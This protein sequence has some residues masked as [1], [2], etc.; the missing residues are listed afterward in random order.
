MT[1]KLGVALFGVGRAGLIHL[2]NLLHNERAIVYYL[3]E[4]DLAKARDVIQKYHMRDTNAV[5]A[6]DTSQVYHDDRYCSQLISQKMILSLGCSINTIT[7][8]LLVTVCFIDEL[9]LILD[10]FTF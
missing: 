2:L 5:S 3:V 10:I 8:Y 1:E 6:D 9:C 4:R 7:S